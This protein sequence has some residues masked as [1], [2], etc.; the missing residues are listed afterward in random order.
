MNTLIFVDVGG[1]DLRFA[2][3]HSPRQDQWLFDNFLEFMQLGPEAAEK[4][5]FLFIPEDHI[6]HERFRSLVNNPISTLNP[7]LYFVQDGQKITRGGSFILGDD[8]P[9]VEIKR[10]PNSAVTLDPKNISLEER[11]HSI[12]QHV[13]RV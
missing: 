11:N 3:N 2:I 1:N 6:R 7:T 10:V 8:P 4:A 13:V 5:G 12:F 9:P